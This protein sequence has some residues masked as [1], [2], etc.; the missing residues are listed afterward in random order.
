[1]IVDAITSALE[2]SNCHSVCAWHRLNEN[3]VDNILPTTEPNE[4]NKIIRMQVFL[5]SFAVYI[6][7]S[8]RFHSCTA[9]IVMFASFPP[10]N[11]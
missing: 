4:S 9:E 5:L 3:G 10:Q 11:I 7:H 8:I 2:V 1:M 6:S